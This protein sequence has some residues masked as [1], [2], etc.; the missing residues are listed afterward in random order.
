[1]AAALGTAFAM[2]NGL[3]KT[4][5]L[6]WST[7]KTCGDEGC[8]HDYCDEAEV[9]TAAEAMQTNGMLKLGYNYVLLDDCW[10]ATSRQP[11]DTLTWDTDRF[12]SG[13]PALTSWL[14][15]RGFRFGLYT[16]AGDTTCSSGGR[17]GSVPGSR[18]HYELDVN[19]FAD[20]GVDYIKLDWCGDIKDQVWNL[21]SAHVAFGTAVLQAKRPMYLEVVAGYWGLLG[22]VDQYANS[23]RFCEDHKDTWSSTTEQLTCRLDQKL[24]VAGAPGGWLYMDMIGTGGSGCAG[25]IAHCPGQS[26]NEYM[27]EFALWTLTQSPLIVNTDVRNMTAIMNKLL[28]NDEILALHQSTVTPPGSFLSQWLCAEALKCEIWARQLAVD[29]SDW[30]VALL[31]KGSAAHSMTISWSE[32]GWDGN[33]VAVVR[34]LWT[35][36]DLQDGATGKYEAE[37]VPSHS[38]ALLRLR[39]QNILQV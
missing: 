26:E 9:K 33:T 22:D 24:G 6:G 38:A 36:K 34:D 7:W 12:P 28:L 21:K 16:S 2:P 17:P 31:N 19:T 4:P 8:T 3:G 13:I 14:H 18:G 25:P 32:L 27:A 35:Q 29:G 23:W 20:W 37:K 10:A 1:L 39:K 5:P 11:N 30:M 15:E